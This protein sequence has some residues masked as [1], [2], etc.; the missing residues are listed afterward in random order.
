MLHRVAMSRD[1]TPFGLR[2]PPDL[3]KKVEASAK[4]EGRSLNAEICARLLSSF[5][6]SKD[7][8]ADRVKDVETRL[9]KLES[10]KTKRK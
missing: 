4:R 2:M 10:A 8:L 7:G 9:D 5:D 3:K 6:A 1:I